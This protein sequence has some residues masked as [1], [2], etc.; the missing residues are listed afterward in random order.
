MFCFQNKNTHLKI[1]KKKCITA[2]YFITTLFLSTTFDAL[3]P[4]VAPTNWTLSRE[5]RGGG[6]GGWS[7]GGRAQYLEAY[8][9]Q[10][11]SH[12]R[13]TTEKVTADSGSETPEGPGP[14]HTG[15][16]TWHRVPTVPSTRHG[17]WSSI[18]VNKEIHR[19]LGRDSFEMDK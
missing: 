13:P 3:S 18:A 8:S 5:E 4:D 9:H 6:Y 14:S 1:F 19:D 12:G 15:P 11:P 17:R 16:D 2:P 7:G 10:Q